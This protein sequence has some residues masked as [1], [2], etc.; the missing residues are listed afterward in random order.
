V[1]GS[2]A[3]YLGDLLLDGQLPQ[4]YQRQGQKKA[5]ATVK[6]DEGIVEGAGDLYPVRL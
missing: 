2:L 5:D 3:T 6:D 4:C 1:R